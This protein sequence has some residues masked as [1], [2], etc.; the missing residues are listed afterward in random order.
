MKRLRTAAL[1]LAHPSLPDA[2]SG[3]RSQAQLGQRG[4][5]VQPGASD[6]D[7]PSAFHE[8][9]V[10]L[11]VR[12][13]RVLADAEGRVDREKRQQSM[14]ELG[15]LRRA[16]GPGQ[17]LEPVVDLQRIGRDGHGILPQALQPL[18][19]RDRDRGLADPGGPEQRDHLRP[20][21]SC[22]SIVQPRLRN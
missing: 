9:T 22:A 15:S 14:F 11:G 21:H 16:G 12:E 3:H 13:L 7:R 10:D 5:E 2:G 6:D 4:A 17:D 18:R 20:R 1:E 19:K 8:Q